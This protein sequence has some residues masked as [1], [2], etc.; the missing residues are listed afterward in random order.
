MCPHTA[1]YVS[2]YCEEG[3]DTSVG[4]GGTVV[5]TLKE[6]PLSEDLNGDALVEASKDFN[7]TTSFPFLSFSLPTFSPT[8]RSLEDT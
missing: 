2:S 6:D 5:E 8:H 1:I 3:R 4:P 7:D